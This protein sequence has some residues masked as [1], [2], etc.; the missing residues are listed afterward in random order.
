MKTICKEERV[1]IAKALMM[2]GDEYLE[3]HERCAFLHDAAVALAESDTDLSSYSVNG[4]RHHSRRI[5]EEL[6]KFGENLEVLRQKTITAQSN[7]D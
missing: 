2:L 5:K 4:L 3:L 7:G 1:G 6:L